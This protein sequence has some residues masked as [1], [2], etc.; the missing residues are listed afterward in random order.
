MALAAVCSLSLM[1][2]LHIRENA[3]VVNQIGLW[4]ACHIEPLYLGTNAF[5]PHS[6]VPWESF[7]RREGA[8]HTDI[9]N[10]ITFFWP[11]HILTVVCFLLYLINASA[12][13]IKYQRIR[14]KVEVLAFWLVHSCLIVLAWTGH[15]L[16]PNFQ[17]KLPVL[18]FQTGLFATLP[19]TA[20]A[21]IVTIINWVFIIGR[22]RFA[23]TLD[24]ER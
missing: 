23:S 11:I 2:D 13:M 21:L 8:M 17:Q 7:L 12:A 1:I 22:G 6:F 18:G 9:M 19:Y 14:I 10:S 16:P 15:Y 5:L 20:L 4:I 3:V 24:K